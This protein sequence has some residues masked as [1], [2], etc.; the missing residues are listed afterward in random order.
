MGG[1]CSLSLH[2]KLE[3]KENGFFCYQNFRVECYGLSMYE[4]ESY[5]KYIL[6]V[7]RIVFLEYK[8]TKK[9]FARCCASGTF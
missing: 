4:N 5:Y 3:N 1:G 7:N 6:R 2:S 8:S 9:I